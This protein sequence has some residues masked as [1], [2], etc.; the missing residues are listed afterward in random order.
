M[1][2]RGIF[3]RT[4][5]NPLKN[6]T[7]AALVLALMTVTILAVLSLVT[8]VAVNQGTSIGGGYKS[9][10]NAVYLAD[11]GADMATGILK[12]T[13]GN[14]MILSSIDTSNTAISITSVS[15]LQTKLSGAGGTA[16]FNDASMA[17][18]YPDATVTIAGNK[19]NMTLSY[20]KSAPLPGSSTESAARYEGIGAGSSGGVGIYYMI[21]ANSQQSYSKSSTV[22]VVYKCIEGGGRCL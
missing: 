16:T 9:Y 20:L 2:K 22:R 15:Y 4:A 3:M 19:I 6:E 8:I 17:A 7:G 10:Q 18:S 5:K 11:G 13:V 21:D 1:T 14:G 12:R